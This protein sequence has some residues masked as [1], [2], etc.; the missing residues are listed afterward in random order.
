METLLIHKDVAAKFLPKMIDVYRKAGA[1]F[2]AAQTLKNH[3]ER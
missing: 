1:K 3:K 2:A